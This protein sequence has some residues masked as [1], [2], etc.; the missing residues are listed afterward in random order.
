LCEK[1]VELQEKLGPQITVHNS[2]NT[3]LSGF[4]LKI[5]MSTNYKKCVSRYSKELLYWP[6][7]NFYSEIWRSRVLTKNYDFGQG[8]LCKCVPNHVK[9]VY[10]PI[11]QD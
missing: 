11:K 5:G 6:I 10:E 8:L 7:L 2:F 9:H 1:R 4:A 3:N